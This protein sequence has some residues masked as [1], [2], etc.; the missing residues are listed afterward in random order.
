[1][2]KRRRVHVLLFISL[3][4]RIENVNAGII[5]AQ[6]ANMWSFIVVVA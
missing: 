5:H 2:S 4:R 1:M 6:G 3:K